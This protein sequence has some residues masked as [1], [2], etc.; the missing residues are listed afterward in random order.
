MLSLIKPI[1]PKIRTFK[2]LYEWEPRFKYDCLDC[3]MFSN[4]KNNG[5]GGCARHGE[6]CFKN[7]FLYDMTKWEESKK[8][9]KKRIKESE[10]IELD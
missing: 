6:P 1:L 8:E 3:P 2:L 10:Y 5:L 4:V 9:Y 7:P